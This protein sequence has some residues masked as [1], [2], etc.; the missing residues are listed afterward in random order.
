MKL[1]YLHGP[2]ASGKLTIARV[3]AAKTGARVL[4]NHASLDFARTLFDYGNPALW[5]LSQAARLLAM[6]HA[7]G[8]GLPL[9]VC[10]Y[11]YAEPEDRPHFE[12]VRA[13]IEGAGGA[14]LPVFLSCER[15]QLYARVGNADRAERGKLGSAGGLDRFLDQWTIA[16]VPHPACFTLDSGQLAPDAAVGVIV[17][18]FALT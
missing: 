8:A 17:T 11:C 9:L 12:E 10:T 13:L 3:L 4:D 7:I 5:R 2:P 15:E 16:P 14:L 18:R 6:Q 1:V